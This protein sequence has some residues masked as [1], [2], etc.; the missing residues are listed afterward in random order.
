MGLL[1]AKT[2]PDIL[3]AAAN[4]SWWE[5]HK[6]ACPQGLVPTENELSD[7]LLQ[8]EPGM[9]AANDECGQL[10]ANLYGQPSETERERWFGWLPDAGEPTSLSHPSDYLIPLRLFSAREKTRLGHAIAVLGASIADVHADWVAKGNRPPHPL[11]PLMRAW[12]A[13]KVMQ[14]VEV[15]AETRQD[16]RIL[17]KLDVQPAHPD[18]QRG[19]LIGGGLIDA[20]RERQLPLLLDVADRNRVPILEIVD[21]TGMPIMAR[22]KGAPLELRFAV[23]SLVAVKPEDRQH[24]S[25]RIAVTLDELAAAMYPRRWRNRDWPKLRHVLLSMRDYGVPV[26]GGRAL[27]FPWAVRKLPSLEAPYGSDMIVIDLAFPPGDADGPPVDLATLDWL[28]V[29]SAPRYRAFLASLTLAY[30]KGVTRIPVD[31]RRGQWR[32]TKDITRYPVIT[33]TERQRLAFGATDRKNRTRAEIDS[34]FRDLPGL[35]V[36]EDAFDPQSGL[37][38]WRVAPA[39]RFDPTGENLDPTGENLDPTGENLDPTGES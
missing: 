4:F 26:D 37:K 35:V 33:R 21:A 1:E 7:T 29:E 22:G 6:K 3:T 18:R 12:Q 27:W 15:Q 11:L 32:W 14:P 30:R 28:G 20:P 19:M 13:W 39:D 9:L 23:R 5:A 36:F 24:T 2:V 17:P 25:V 16:R 34:A 31:K 38:G 10:L 8:E